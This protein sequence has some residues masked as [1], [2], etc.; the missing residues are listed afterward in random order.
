MPK[1]N[2]V[3]PVEKIERAIFLI[4]GQKVMLD[5]DLAQLYGVE[6]R[7]L[8]QAVRRNT[9]RFPADFMFELTRKEIM[10]ISQFV[11]SS[12]LKFSR[13]VLAFTQEGVAMLSS[14]LRSKR[15]INVTILIP[16]VKTQSSELRTQH[17]FN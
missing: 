1:T 17:F 14:V 4:R 9:E 3:I 7:V 15:A 5:K 11:I 13:N 16:S 6:T 2:S 8:N 10:R 12:D